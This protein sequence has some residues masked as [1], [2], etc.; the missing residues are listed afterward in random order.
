MNKMFNFN[1]MPYK[2]SGRAGGKSVSTIGMLVLLL[3]ALMLLPSCTD[4]GDTITEGPDCGE[5]TELNAAGDECVSI[6]DPVTCDEGTVLNAAGDAC[7]PDPITE[8]DPIGT[9]SAEN[10]YQDGDRDGMIA[11]TDGADFI[12]GEGGNDSIKGM[13]GNDDITGGPGDDRLY[14]GPGDD[15]LDGGAGNDTI[16]GMAGDDDLIG[17]TGNNAIDGGDGEDTANY[18]G[19]TEVK[20]DLNAGTAVNV[21]MQA[22]RFSPPG[23]TDSLANIENV[24]GSPGADIID[25]DDNANRLEGGDGADVINGHGGDDTIIPNRAVAV[26]GETPTDGVDVVDGGADSD[27]LS[28][29]GEADTVTMTIDLGTVVAATDPDGTPDSGDE[30]AAHITA[31]DGTTDDMIVVTGEGTTEDPHVST[32]ENLRGGPGGDNLSGDGQANTIEGGGGV[33]TLSGAG[34]DDMLIGGEGGDTLNGGE[35]ND[36]LMGGEGDDDLNGDAGNDTLVGGEGDDDL[37]GGEGND[38]YVGVASGEMGDLTEPADQA[39]TM[40]VHEGGVDTLHFAVLEDDATTDPDESILTA[41]L[42]ANVE[43]VIGTPNVD[44]L[45]AA[46]TG[47]TILGLEGDDT[48][49]GGAGV[50]TLVGCAGENTLTGNAGS[51]V[52]GVFNDDANADSITDF[53]TGADNATTD[54][55]HLKGFAAD[56]TVTVSVIANNITHAA[57]HVD[58]VTVATVGSTAI[59]ADT[60]DG[61]PA[62]VEKTQAENIV[63]ALGKNNS[64]GEAVVRIVEFD[65]AKCSLSSN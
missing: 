53:T 30:V 41:T 48:L 64:D 37:D 5:G 13:D 33:D 34:G 42:P 35:G 4:D 8:Y 57:V 11:G 16:D 36:H 58:G 65:S 3:A 50:D 56:A 49:I 40:D 31:G 46:A 26:A 59:V 28:Y 20:V 24:K 45:T 32:I 54:E 22:D 14:G 47:V 2:R 12:D 62:T 10:R 39:G 29:E 55:I 19:S 1:G 23:G 51:D 52:F 15:K 60:D 18:S 27:T 7:V 61:D 43:T 17:G 6:V 44:N 21:V 25:G 38:T 63:A 9:T